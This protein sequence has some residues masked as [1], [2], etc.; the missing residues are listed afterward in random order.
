MTIPAHEIFEDGQKWERSPFIAR[1]GGN[2]KSY[3]EMLIYICS[4]QYNE[5]RT[6]I[7]KSRSGSET[8]DQIL[9][10]NIIDIFTRLNCGDTSLGGNDAINCYPQ[11]GED[12]DIVHPMTASSVTTSIDGGL[13]AITGYGRVY[14]E[15]Y[16][17]GQKVLWITAGT[18]KFMNV[19][20]FYQT[21]VDPN[22]ADAINGTENISR[23]IGEAAG[24]L[25]MLP[26][27]IMLAP[28]RYFYRAMNMLKYDKVSKYY[29]FWSDQIQYYQYVNTMLTHLAV[30]MG[31]YPGASAHESNIGKGARNQ[32]VK[33][34]IKASGDE[35]YLAG[36]L[37]IQGSPDGKLEGYPGI[38]EFFQDGIDI[39]TIM[40]KR[41]TYR[42]IGGVENRY[43]ATNAGAG[44]AQNERSSVTREQL[45]SENTNAYW[46][47]AQKGE[48]DKGLFSS[49]GAFA[50]EMVDSAW[51]SATQADK[52]IGFRIEKSTDSSESFSNTTGTS[53]IAETINS[54]ASS[55]RQAMF[56][57]GGV[58]EGASEA[59][60][61]SI[62]SGIG[63]VVKSA[64]DIFGSAMD[65]ITG[66]LSGTFAETVIK[67]NAYIDIPEIWMNSQFSKSY[68]F[69][70][71][72]FDPHGGNPYSWMIN[73]G[74]PLC[75]LLALALPRSTGMNSYG[76]PFLIRA[77][78]DGMFAV[79]LGIVDNMSVTRGGSEHGWS[80]YGLPTIVEVS[81]SIKD[82]ATVMH[83]AL[84]D[85]LIEGMPSILGQNSPFQEYLLTLSNVSKKERL[86][87]WSKTKR[88][89]NYFLT[90][91][92]SQY[93]NPNYWGMKIGHSTMGQVYGAFSKF[94]GL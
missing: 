81:W 56:S 21:A 3:K 2:F 58:T 39:F 35:S 6:E 86:L 83:M 57:I 92:Q 67:G 91:I 50:N 10:D 47:R 63:G 62:V 18:T 5:L 24:N 49:M 4:P 76:S 80:I 75:C 51:N 87:F 93:A 53:S 32:D 54:Q 34:T 36:E 88:L 43:G 69:R 41:E 37:G 59:G 45:R 82:L 11:F 26:F 66:G 25:L 72:L 79:P 29:D 90:R 52:Y 16:D 70:T 55:A 94:S 44:E 48:K 9:D 40:S 33:G 12:D 27:K 73:I 65:S 31:L 17:T 1:L 77:Y 22:L 23:R 71:T 64:A 15:V 13:T 30:N 85:G 28:I 89:K 61:G 7:D 84:A 68:S 46:T 38:P 74:V 19:V 42:G 60:L 8:K 78:C 20:E 14:S